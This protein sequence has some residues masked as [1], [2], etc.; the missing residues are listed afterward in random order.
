MADTY[1]DYVRMT[2]INASGRR[3]SMQLRYPKENLTALELETAMDLILDK[4]IFVST[5]G[6]FTDTAEGGIVERIYTSLIA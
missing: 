1:N 2:F 4:N 6:E 5:G 3:S